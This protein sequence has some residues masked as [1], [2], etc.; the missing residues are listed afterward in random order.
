MMR[1]V[2]ELH[3]LDIVAT[4]GEIGS[5]E[6]FYFDDDRWTIRYLVVDTGMW[7]PGRKVLISPISIGRADWNARTLSL[8]VTRQQVRDSPDADTHKPLS[9]RY[10]AEYHRYYGYPYY[11]GTA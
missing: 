8:S 7:L 1:H 11:W 6:E 3:G 5:V 10:E 2:K 4:D 9:R